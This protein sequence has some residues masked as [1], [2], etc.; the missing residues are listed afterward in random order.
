LIKCGAGVPPA[1]QFLFSTN[2]RHVS[3]NKPINPRFG[4]LK[5]RGELPHLYVEGGTYF[6][7][8]RLFDAVVP[9]SDSASKQRAN[10]VDADPDDP[11]ILLEEYDPP[12][13]LGSCTLAQAPL[14]E[15]VQNAI[16]HFD[17]ER[18][19]LIAWCVMPNHVHAIFAPLHGYMPDQILHSWKSFS[20][21]TINKQLHRSGP[22]WERESF[23]HLVR[24]MR[25]LER[26]IR[27]TEDNPA[28]ASLCK[29]ASEWPHSSRTRYDEQSRSRSS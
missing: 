7:T 8:F 14:A 6:V 26:L 24:N 19:E 9:A 27:Y 28:A 17:G 15:I 23:D 2:Y 20:A 5:S 29:V 21:H 1:F 12:I 4:S 13:T 25:S 18:Y 16:R 3:L 11:V 22:L 10:R